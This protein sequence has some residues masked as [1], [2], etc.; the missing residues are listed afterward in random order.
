MKHLALGI[1]LATFSTPALATPI[2]FTGAEFASLPGI[3]F[4]SGTRS[5]IGDSL[6]IDGNRNFH[7]TVVL[8]LTQFDV[9]PGNFELQLNVTRLL[10]DSNFEDQDLH[11][12]LSDG[13]N[14]FGGTFADFSTSV[15]VRIRQDE[16]NRNDQ[17]FIDGELL[18]VSQFTPVAV[19]SDYLATLSVRATATETTITG[20]INNGAVNFTRT[21]TVLF[22]SNGVGLALVLGSSNLNQNY[23][24]NSVTFSE[25]V[26][27]PTAVSEPGAFGGLALGLT[28]LGFGLYRRRFA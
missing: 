19:G 23:L 1:S 10:N 6:R 11:V 12:Y 20:N 3:S 16:L 27:A 21:S 18:G 15:F 14:L 24:I 22:N 9:D 13:R 2:S 28:T 5:I 26:G 8:P 4:P 17:S 7:A 25:G